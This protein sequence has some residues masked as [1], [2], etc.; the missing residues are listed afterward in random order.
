MFIRF[1]LLPCMRDT[2]LF[3]SVDRTPPCS[4]GKVG[5]EPSKDHEVIP[6][7]LVDRDSFRLRK[8][9]RFRQELK[10]HAKL[11]EIVNL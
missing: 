8:V 9:E 2:A 3:F 6:L 11:F 5:R 1:P 4:T 7:V 10:M